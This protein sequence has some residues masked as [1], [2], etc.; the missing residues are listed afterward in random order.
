MKTVREEDRAVINDQLIRDTL[1][2][3][4]V[5]EEWTQPLLDDSKR[6]NTGINETSKKKSEDRTKGIKNNLNKQ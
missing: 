1:K 5:H 2:I 6:T 4:R 3:T